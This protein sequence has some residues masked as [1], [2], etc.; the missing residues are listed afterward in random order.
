M[1][2]PVPPCTSVIV[3]VPR[4]DAANW[5]PVAPG[6]VVAKMLAPVEKPGVKHTLGAQVE[7]SRE[8]VVEGD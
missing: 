2:P 6:L 7:G 1:P 8:G 3:L 5:R 4:T